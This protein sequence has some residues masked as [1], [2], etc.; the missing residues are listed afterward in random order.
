MKFNHTFV[1]REHL[2][3]QSADNLCLSS[4]I[5]NSCGRRFL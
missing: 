5:K 3:L 2:S 1:L 4:T